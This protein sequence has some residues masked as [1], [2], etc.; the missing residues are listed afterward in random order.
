MN[1]YEELLNILAE[2]DEEENK[3]KQEEIKLFDEQIEEISKS[4]IKEAVKH[5]SK[6]HRSNKKEDKFDSDQR[7]FYNR[8]EFET[9]KKLNK[10][11]D[12]KFEIKYDE[13]FPDKVFCYIAYR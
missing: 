9:F 5:F 10:N 2:M 11:P 7:F 3:R 8:T 1:K 13:K 6:R 12:V 4:I